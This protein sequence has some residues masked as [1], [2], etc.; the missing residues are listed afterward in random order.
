MR[1]PRRVSERMLENVA[2]YYLQR[3][4][5]SAES[6]RRVLLRRVERSARVHGTDRGEGAAL[7]EAVVGRCVSAGL[8]DDR[9]FATARAARLHRQGK[10]A[11]AVAAHLHGKGIARDLI[12]AT[13]SAL[14][15][16]EGGDRSQDR[17]GHRDSDWAAAI[18]FARRRRLGPFRTKSPASETH[19]KD[20]AA[21]ARAGF[22]YAIAR[23]ILAAATPEELATAD[24]E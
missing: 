5:A 3:F 12:E 7:V 19:E 23:Q 6:L 16:N 1:Q 11:R 22:S 9:A 10:P 14:A 24:G 4:A 15:A 2:L 17:G 18:H 13:L 20:L 8:V 21:F